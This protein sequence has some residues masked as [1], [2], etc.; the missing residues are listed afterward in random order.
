[1]EVK[2]KIGHDISMSLAGHME[3]Y[4]QANKTENRRLATNRVKSKA[5][6]ENKNDISNQQIQY[7]SECDEV[8]RDIP[9]NVTPKNK[10]T[11]SRLDKPNKIGIFPK[12]ARFCVC[13]LIENSKDHSCSD[14]EAKEPDSMR[15]LDDVSSDS[16]NYYVTSSRD[17]RN[18][19]INKG[20]QSNEI[21]INPKI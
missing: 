14:V 9:E 18:V 17:Q 11:A 5:F 7:E 16:E 15:F 4:D 13:R 20:I 3:A 1:M 6:I 12:S 10:V 19:N 21:K 2:T 8:F